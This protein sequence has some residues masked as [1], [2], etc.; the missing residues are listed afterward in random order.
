MT[1]KKENKT[2][3]KGLADSFAGAKSVNKRPLYVLGAILLVVVSA[4]LIFVAN[5]G[6]TTTASQD[7]TLANDAL[8]NGDKTLALERAKEAL[9]KDSSNI[10]TILLVAKLTKETSP[11]EAKQYYAQ[12][13]KEYSQQDNPDVSGKSAT[14]YWAAADLAQRAGKTEQAKE[15]YA[16]VA[17][18]A[19][20]QDDYELSIAEQSKERLEGLQ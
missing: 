20:P 8:I 1:T 13:L 3:E 11:D 15:Y 16:K 7:I 10:D 19:N 6:P 17:P 4:G 5:R 12:A 9:V 18:A 14:V 2:K